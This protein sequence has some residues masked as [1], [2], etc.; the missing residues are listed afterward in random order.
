MSV[1]VKKCDV[2]GVNID[3]KI[4]KNDIMETIPEHSFDEHKPELAKYMTETRWR[5]LKIPYGTRESKQIV[6]IS[7]KKPNKPREYM[8]KQMQ[9]TVKD[10]DIDG[11]FDKYVE[12]KYY[13]YSH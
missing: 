12:E 4:C 1:F 6:E 3:L 5:F 7:R 8:N 10:V 11:S 9:W 2:S 13:Y